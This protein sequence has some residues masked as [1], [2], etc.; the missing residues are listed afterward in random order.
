MSFS[1][2]LCTHN[3]GK[4]Y[5]TKCLDNITKALENEDEIIV[6]DDYSNY[7]TLET[8]KRYNIQFFQHA[9]NKNFAKQKNFLLSKC[10]KDYIFL[11][12]AD[13]YI[14]FSKI[15]EIKS[16]VKKFLNYDAWYIPRKN[17]LL[18]TDE[19]TIKEM[20]WN[21]QNG[22]FNYPDYQLRIF[23][24]NKNI[25]FEGK[26]H[27]QVVGYNNSNKLPTDLDFDIIHVKTQERQLKQHFFYESIK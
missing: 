24:N 19:K 6:V 12:D 5:I 27:E 22:L 20:N 9:L 21:I 14:D 4:D 11:F 3:E 17:I 25:H 23:K 10:N 8:I 26:L 13:E 1:F 7:E 2:C 16:I 15:L 18:N